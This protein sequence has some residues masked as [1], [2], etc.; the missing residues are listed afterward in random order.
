MRS[1]IHIRLFGRIVLVG[2]K[3]ELN[4]SGGLGKGGSVSETELELTLR[5]VSEQRRQEDC[6]SEFCFAFHLK[7]KV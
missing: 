4:E 3:K 1:K 6:V 2:K 5:H 7:M